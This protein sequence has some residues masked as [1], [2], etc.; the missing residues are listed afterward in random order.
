VI[1]ITDGEQRSALAVVRSLGKAGYAVGVC[2]AHAKPLAGASRHCR[3]TFRTP[4]PASDPAAFIG[5]IEGLVDSNPVELV[6]PMT[7]VT[8]PLLLELRARRP[9]VALPFPS[10][11]KY[12]DL[13]DK[14]LLT[15]V[16]AGLGVPV[17]RQV[18]IPDEGADLKGLLHA[19]EVAG[20]PW[21]MILKPARSAGQVAGGV[22]KFG[23]RAVDS[24]DALEAELARF[25]PEAYPFLLQE[26]IVGPGIGVFL[27]GDVEGRPLASFGHRRIREKPPTGGISVYRESIPVRQDLQEY[28]E[29][30]STRFGWSGVVMLEFKEDASTGTPYLME[31]NARFWGSL[32]LAIDAG[33]DFPRLLVQA[34]LGETVEPVRHYRIG[35]RSRWLWGDFD[36]LLWML[37]APA[38]QRRLYPSLPG[39]ARAIGRFLL[40]WRP[41]DRFEVLRWRDLRPFV[42]ESVQWFQSLGG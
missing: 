2:S 22:R 23:V 7:D 16:A 34:A 27:L 14:S 26:R 33:V 30:I 24:A 21:P 25:P 10:L 4:D 38:S 20:L 39:R 11:A 36:H 40:P 18:V 37:R 5:A 12:R 9:E 42:R 19:V 1:L 8:A 13:S 28:S 32:Q 29:R 6:I 41:G 15:D 35:V 3:V 17:P 31:A